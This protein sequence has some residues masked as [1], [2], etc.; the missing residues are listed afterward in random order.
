MYAPYNFLRWACFNK[1]IPNNVS[2]VCSNPLL[3]KKDIQ[4][5]GDIKFVVSQDSTDEDQFTQAIVGISSYI[6]GIRDVP[7]PTIATEMISRFTSEW[8]MGDFTDTDKDEINYILRIDY[9]NIVHPIATAIF[10]LN[11]M[12]VIGGDPLIYIGNEEMA[13]GDFTFTGETTQQQIHTMM[14]SV[15]RVFGIDIMPDFVNKTASRWNE[16]RIKTRDIY[17][18]SLADYSFCKKAS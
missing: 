16:Q 18:F 1:L 10:V 3:D 6:S 14:C 7:I 12:G 5:D 17:G 15:E 8:M 9:T 2:L 4:D 13:S 11:G